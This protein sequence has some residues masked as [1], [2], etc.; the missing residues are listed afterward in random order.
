MKITTKGT[1]VTFSYEE[2]FILSEAKNILNQLADL[3]E[4]EHVTEIR[5]DSCCHYN[6]EEILS[7]ISFCDETTE[8]TS[9]DF[10]YEED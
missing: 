6:L 7:F 2:S 3:M 4:K 5:N 9:W 1:K 8:D 10:I